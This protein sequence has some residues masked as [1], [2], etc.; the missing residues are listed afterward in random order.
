MGLL[1]EL[2]KIDSRTLYE[3]GPALKVYLDAIFAVPFPKLV[4]K[5]EIPSA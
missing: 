2:P 1:N 4:E 5:W 3:E